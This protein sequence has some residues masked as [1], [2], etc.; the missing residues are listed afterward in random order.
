[1]PRLNIPTPN[2]FLFIILIYILS[3][4]RLHRLILRTMVRNPLT[5]PLKPSAVRLRPAAGIVLSLRLGTLIGGNYS[6]SIEDFAIP[7]VV[8]V[9]R[10]WQ[11]NESGKT[12]SPVNG[13]S[14]H[15]SLSPF[16]VG[17]TP[18]SL[19]LITDPF[20]TDRSRGSVGE[21]FFFFFCFI[22][23]VFPETGRKE[24]GPNKPSLF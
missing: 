11:A 16:F 21:F 1:M 8:V 19:A 24:K 14:P 9:R 2:L 12:R 13:L 22:C 23:C 20:R 6:L 7:R 18:A 10:C 17:V 15:L 5:P 3:L 4:K